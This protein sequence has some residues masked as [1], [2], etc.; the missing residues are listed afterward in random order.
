MEPVHISVP[1]YVH[2]GWLPHIAG[3]TCAQSR[4]VPAQAGMDVQEHPFC[5]MHEAGSV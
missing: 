2:P 3:G 1:V 4:M 5:V